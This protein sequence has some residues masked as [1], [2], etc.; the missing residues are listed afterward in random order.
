MIEPTLADVLDA[1]STIA[2]YLKPTPFLKSIPLSKKL[3]FDAYI[4]CENLQP[5]GAFKIRGG[6]NLISKLTDD[7]RR[8]GVI[9]ASTGNHGLSIAYASALFGV[10]ATIGAPVGSNPYKIQAIRDVGARVELH[11]KDFDEARLWVEKTAQAKRYRYIHSANEPL[12]IAGV[13]TLYLEILE[14]LPNVDVIFVPVG[15]GSGASG[16]CI[17]AKT[18]NPSIKVIG[19]QSEGAPAVYESWKRGKMV[20]KEKLETFA[21]GLATRVPFELTMRIMRRLIDKIMLVSEED[22]K[23]AI[24]LLLETTHQVAEGA[25]AASTAGAVKM[26][27]ELIGKKVALVISGG[28]LTTDMLR[29]ILFKEKSQAVS[30]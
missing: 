20:E 13:G 3:G 25:G 14:D 21:D 27:H 22:L 18:I 28:N 26:R 29:E 10:Q 23:E 7:E 6:I 5:T 9:T 11:G 15:G 12:L 4:K 1:R 8:R 19:V 17:V 16:A 2:K 24:R 30:D